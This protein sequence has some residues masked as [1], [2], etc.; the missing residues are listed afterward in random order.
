MSMFRV[1]NLRYIRSQPLRASLAVIAMSAA[2]AGAVAGAVLI[3]SLDRSLEAGLRGFAG[4]APIRVIGPL[5]RGG[6]TP[7]VID[8]VTAVD[9]VETAV[10]VVT[11]IAVAQ[12]VD[13]DPTYIV[14]LGFDCRIEAV[15]GAFGCDARSLDARKDGPVLI[16]AA[17]V[18]SVG[19]DADIRTDVGRVPIEGATV[20]DAL[21]GF[22]GGRVAVFEMST[23]QRLFD[24]GRNIDA[25]YV[26]P[27]KGADVDGLMSE[28]RGVVGDQNLVLRS[29]DPAPWMQSR[30]PLIPLLGVGL[31][32]SLGLS[33][34]LVYNVLSLSLADRR[35]DLAVASAIGTSP[36]SLTAGI[37]AESSLLGLAGG[38][39]GIA[40]GLLVARPLVGSFASV[41]SESATGLRV[42][43]FVPV[44]AY[45][46]GL[47]VGIGVG[48][49]SAIVPARRAVRLDL[50]AEL[51]GRAALE[52]ERPRRA[53]PRVVLLLAGSAAT[54]ALS[55]V[56]IRG[57][58]IEPWQPPLG[59]VC[60]FSATLLMFAAVG[61][62]SPMVIGV[63]ARY[64]RNGRG[65]L[66]LAIANLVSRPRRTRVIA[67]AVGSAVGLACVLGALIPATRATIV[68]SEV[69]GDRAGVGLTTLP[70]NNASNVDARPSKTVLEKVK[71][72]DGVHAAGGAYVH[73]ITD[74]IGVYSVRAFD[75]TTR[76]GFKPVRG[77]VGNA[78]LQRGDAVIGT[79]LARTRGL[80]PGSTLAISTPTGAVP[81]TVAG[82]WVSSFDNGF[83][84]IVSPQ[85]FR[86]LFGSPAPNSIGVD[87]ELG[88]TAD[89]LA[90]RI[91][92]ANLDPDLNVRTGAESAVA[93]SD[94]IADQASPFWM[95]QRVLLL[96]AL[97]GTL[98]TL[99]LV[100]VQ[101]RRELGVLGAVGFTPTALGRM[102]LSEALAACLAGSLLGA[103]ASLALFE[104]LRNASAVS[105][106]VRSEYRVE[107][108]SALAATALALVVVA[109]GAALPAWR[110]GRVQI[111]EAIRDE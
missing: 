43:V 64:S 63:L 20:N 35:R 94:E 66:R 78:P 96:V 80:R 103:I 1:L 61:T 21:D 75:G 101:R 71:R 69:V 87:A 55:M 88:V 31:L 54:M 19:K 58:A 82:I 3:N 33:G 12:R 18:R 84:A 28:L 29:D 65:P 32:L 49:V 105:I 40:G 6:L 37:V 73:E 83:N 38:I 51:H 7:E 110:A 106:G 11:A 60:I 56:S 70:L 85:L 23:A 90:D 98:S 79:S 10:P 27:D 91:R 93:L 111:V 42:S 39:L 41:I 72:L 26:R 104:V 48:A 47:V 95:L 17:L 46:V 53:L 57:G 102:T 109:V 68:R 8:R 15:V 24:R 22:N 81:M 77:E 52:E 34:L 4:P 16:S 45:I 108:L 107:P 67:T 5:T 97:V 25:I 86:R 14:A 13:G 59:V 92:A 30:G 76:W 99:L 2:V 50:A 62:V 44:A 36:A 74:D 89:E 100:G 9:G